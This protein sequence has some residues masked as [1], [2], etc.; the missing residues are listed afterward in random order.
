MAAL[1]RAMD[2]PVTSLHWH[3][4]T[5]E[6][7]IDAIGE[8]VTGDLEEARPS[9]R[10]DRPWD[11]ELVAGYTALR[12]QL[13]KVPGFLGLALD[14]SRLLARPAVKE[15]I[16][17]RLEA[18]IEVLTRAGFTAEDAYRVRHVCSVY[19]RGFVLLERAASRQ[20]HQP[21]TPE[22]D[23]QVV[24]PPSFPL[25][26]QIDLLALSWDDADRQFRFGLEALV[27]GLKTMLAQQLS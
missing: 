26:S 1:A 27:A 20:Y 14:R 13:L 8:R 25:L 18:E 12:Q 3:F 6:D 17:E 23:S 10:R 4:R 11:E 19:V 22:T 16:T 15:M 5:R 24:A 2:V 7:L 21:G 9:P